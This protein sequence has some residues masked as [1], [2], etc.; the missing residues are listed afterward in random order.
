MKQYKSNEIKNIALLGHGG[1]GKTTLAD[2]LLFSFGKIDR[3]GKTMILKRKNALHRYTP[4]FI[5][6]KWRIRK[7]I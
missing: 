4:Q 3:I 6:L 1:S 2:A 7:L 5:L